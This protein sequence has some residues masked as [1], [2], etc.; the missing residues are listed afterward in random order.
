[1]PNSSK[2]LRA[3][4]VGLGMMGRHHGRVLASLDGVEL[5]GVCDP[6]GDPHGVAGSRPLVASVEELIKL[7]VSQSDVKLVTVPGALELTRLEG[8]TTP[9]AAR[10]DIPWLVIPDVRHIKLPSG[11]SLCCL[12]P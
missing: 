9:V 11:S 10:I 12:P 5:V 7:G 8:T 3:G 1:M 4:L 2:K 6:M